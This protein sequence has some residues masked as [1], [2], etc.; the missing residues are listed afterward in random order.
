MTSWSGIYAPATPPPG[1]TRFSLQFGGGHTASMAHSGKTAA[2][3]LDGQLSGRRVYSGAGRLITGKQ[4]Q[5]KVLCG[6]SQAVETVSIQLG[7]QAAR[8]IAL[9]PNRSLSLVRE[10]NAV[11][12]RWVAVVTSRILYFHGW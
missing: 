12:C 10:N 7:S 5:P 8:H 9:P 6:I 2:L 3:H 11:G 1:G 4:R